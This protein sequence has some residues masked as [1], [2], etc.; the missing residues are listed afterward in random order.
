[1]ITS[2]NTIIIYFSAFFL[3][4]AGICYRE[5]E[6]IYLNVKISSSVIICMLLNNKF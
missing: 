1:M 6:T 3:Q 5:K 4:A 2:D